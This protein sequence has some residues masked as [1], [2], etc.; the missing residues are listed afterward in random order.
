MKDFWRKLITGREK[1]VIS[2]CAGLSRRIANKIYMMKYRNP[3][4]AER[5]MTR[6]YGKED[7]AS[8]TLAS[9]LVA[10]LTRDASREEAAWVENIESLRKE[11]SDSPSKITIVDYGA[12]QKCLNPDSGPEEMGREK[13]VTKTIG[14]TCQTVCKRVLLL[15]RLVREFRP[16]L[17]LELGTGLGISAAYQTAALELNGHG[18]L[19]TVEGAENLASLARENFKRLGLNRV[20]VV[21][22]RFQDKLDGL[23]REYAPVDFAFIDGHHY[24]RATLSYFEKVL[25]FLSEGGLLVFDNII[26]SKGMMRAWRKIASDRRIGLSIDLVKIGICV[27]ANFLRYKRHFNINPD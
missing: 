8:K 19:V 7:T 14:D 20:G 13:V 18:R 24:E 1:L 25:P 10:A 11:L 21:V 4:K 2:Y 17:C 12:G 23:L 9:N 22:G 15:F 5:S 6:I 27:K 3:K 16:S 26:W